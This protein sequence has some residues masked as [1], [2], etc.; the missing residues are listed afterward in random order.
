MLSIPCD[1]FSEVPLRCEA[2][3]CLPF[4]RKENK[5]D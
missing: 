2:A 1:I 3:D 5:S 4:G